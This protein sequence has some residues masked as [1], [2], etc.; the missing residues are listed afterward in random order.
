MEMDSYL[1]MNLKKV[2]I[3]KIFIIKLGYKK[4]FNIEVDENQLLKLFNDIDIEKN[5]LM[6]Y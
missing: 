6:D 1:L 3:L 5:G 2:I 4:A